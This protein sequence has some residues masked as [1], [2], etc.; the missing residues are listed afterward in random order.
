MKTDIH[1]CSTCRIGSE[2]WEEYY[3]SI[4]LQ[5]MIQYDY[6]H[7]DGELFS[8]TA[9]SL[10]KARAKRNLWFKRHRNIVIVETP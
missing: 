10:D 7:T 4:Y 5:T 9:K 6:R 3:S 8:C 1:G 2:Q